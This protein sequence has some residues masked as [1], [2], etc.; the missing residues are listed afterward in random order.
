MAFLVDWIK[1]IIL[2]VL[3][4]IVI[5][6]LL[7][8]NNMRKYIKLVVGLILVVMFLKPVFAL[9]QTNIS[10]EINKHMSALEQGTD[11]ESVKNL[12]NLQ[13]T[14]IQASTDAYI[15]EEMSKQLIHEAEDS[16]LEEHSIEIKQIVF[17]FQS[18]EERTYETLHTMDVYIQTSEGDSEEVD[19]I[20]RVEEVIIHPNEQVE[21]P[22][23]DVEPIINTLKD[24]WEVHDKNIS[25]IWGEGLS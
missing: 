25:I 19:T 24:V 5:D 1:Q 22:E 6:L 20:A 23:E 7:P 16:L 8:S 4:A 13:K 12:I 3:I 11:E 17:Y 18:D 21:Q 9:F 14:D 10:D 15:L 2:F